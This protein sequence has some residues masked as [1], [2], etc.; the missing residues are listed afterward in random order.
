MQGVYGRPVAY[1][2]LVD[3]N[4]VEP[5]LTRIAQISKVA[6]KQP[7]LEIPKEWL[8]GADD[9]ALGVVEEKLL[10]RRGRVADMIDAAQVSCPNRFPYWRAVE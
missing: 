3:M 5:W 1:L 2:N 8:V 10:S 7:F 6:V 4:A 9:E